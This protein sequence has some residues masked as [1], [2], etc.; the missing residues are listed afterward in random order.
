MYSG[1]GVGVGEWWCKVW[2]DG[3]NDT[4]PGVWV[5]RFLVVK[6]ERFHKKKGRVF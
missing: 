6:Y 4:D 2:G 1:G 5:I 3:P